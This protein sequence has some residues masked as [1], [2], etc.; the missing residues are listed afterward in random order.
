MVSPAVD[1]VGEV[2]ADLIGE[3]V[4]VVHV[5]VGQRAWDWGGWEDRGVSTRA[6]EKER[7]RER[8]MRGGSGYG[9]WWDV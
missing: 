6:R 7:E 1:G 2:D 4:R 3:G 8:D 9:S 5:G